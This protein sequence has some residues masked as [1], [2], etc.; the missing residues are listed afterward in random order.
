MLDVENDGRLS[1]YLLLLL[2]KV[3]KPGVNTY[4]YPGHK[5]VSAWLTA[6]FRYC[7]SKQLL[8][9]HLAWIAHRLRSERCGVGVTSEFRGWQF[10]ISAQKPAILTE[11][12]P[13]SL[14]SSDET[15]A[16]D[17][18]VRITLLILYT[19]CIKLKRNEKVTS[20]QSSSVFCGIRLSVFELQSNVRNSPTIF[21]SS[22][23]SSS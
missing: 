10:R 12:F 1:T 9:N 4:M 21:F 19:K 20:V 22:T 7:D 16:L 18:L 13:G 5:I 15:G 8:W 3:S 6:P 17:L 2:W 23:G 11:I 14:P